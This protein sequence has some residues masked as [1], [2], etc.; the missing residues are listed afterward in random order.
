[1]DW[2]V[3]MCL[4]KS[5]SSIATETQGD[6]MSAMINSNI[7][8][9]AQTFNQIM[10]D[11]PISNSAWN[12]W[13]N[14][15]PH[16]LEELAKKMVNSKVNPWVFVADARHFWQFADNVDLEFFWNQMNNDDHRTIHR[17]WS[18][19]DWEMGNK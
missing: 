12:R 5:Y 16:R 7:S 3:R 1:M 13:N 15:D 10:V 4:M 9:F 14:S 19:E 17:K 2:I 11:L 18:D 6:T 8:T